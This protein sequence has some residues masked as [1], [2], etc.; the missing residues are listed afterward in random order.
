[1]YLISDNNILGEIQVLAVNPKRERVQ[2]EDLAV[3]RS[4]ILKYILN[5][6]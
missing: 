3:D 4:I 2:F 1:V 6:N 5:K